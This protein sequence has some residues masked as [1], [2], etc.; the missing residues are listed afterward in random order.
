MNQEVS[1]NP[2][3]EGAEAFKFNDFDNEPTAS[4]KN[5]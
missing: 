1:N 2:A 3:P 4:Y 5:E